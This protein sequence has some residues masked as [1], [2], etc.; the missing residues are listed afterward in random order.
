MKEGSTLSA[1]TCKLWE[2]EIERIEC[3]GEPL[4]TSKPEELNR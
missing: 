2:A 3:G 4:K 1:Y